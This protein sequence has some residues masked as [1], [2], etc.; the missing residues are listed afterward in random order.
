MLANMEALKKLHLG[1]SRVTKEE[2]DFIMGL[3][4]EEDAKEK[5]KENEVEVEVEENENEMGMG[6]GVKLI[7]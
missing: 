2:W 5:E 6:E 4:G 1:V 3:V 7:G